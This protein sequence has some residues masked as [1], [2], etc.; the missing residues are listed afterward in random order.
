MMT[1]IFRPLCLA[2]LL[3]ASSILV[4]AGCHPTQLTTQEAR[5]SQLVIAMPGDP[6][7][8]NYAV[9]TSDYSVF[10]YL[11]S[12]ML[13]ENGLTAELE[14]ALAESWR[15]SA[16]QRQV[17]FTLRPGL[18]W[19]DGQPLTADD[20]LFTFQDIYLNP[21]I[22]TVY[23]DFFRIGQAGALPTVQK[24]DQQRVMFTLPEPFAPLLRNAG[25][26]AIL[27]SHALRDSVQTTDANGNPKFLST[28]S[29]G[30]DPHEIIGNG[31]FWIENYEPDQRLIL[32][33]N[34]YYWRSDSRGYA[35]PYIDRL[36]LQII[37]STDDQLLR[38][39]SG[40]L[41][42][43]GG[44]PEAFSLLKGEEGRG[45]YTIYNGGP[46]ARIRF[47]GFNLNQA[48]DIQGN[49]F[50]DPIKSRWFN[51]L[52]FRQA[53]AYAIDRERIKNSIYQGLGELQHSPI[54]LQSPYYLSPEEGL[55]VYHYDPQKA[56]KLLL[57]A[58]FQYNDDQ[59]L[60]DGQG[61]RVRFTILVKSEEKS[62][63]DT[64][65]LIQ[66][67]L[68]KIGIKADLQVLSF[69]IVL[70]RLLEKRDWEC[71]VGAF[72]VGM[73]EP[74]DVF[75]FWHSAG[76][77]H[78]FN[79]GPQPGN[80]PIED[81]RVSDWEREIDSLF[82]AGVKE[83]DERKRKAIYDQFQQIVAEQAPVFFLVNPLS[84]QA[85]R[86]RVQNVKFSALRGPFWNIEELNIREALN[87]TQTSRR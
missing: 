26:L 82:I 70:Q 85:I 47:V 8:F 79:Q 14:P 73:V 37:S 65:A 78:Q 43:T 30:T 54:G 69:N 83:L 75:L 66:Q 71:Y 62:R 22:P 34:P 48:R 16:D 81:W 68:S 53:V 15:I 64:A 20:V 23:R 6:Q 56:I 40:E 31:P 67:D 27:P 80:P 77:F 28:W 60:M 4:L 41:D 55:K 3:A 84:L 49:P 21:A 2:I 25:T 24:L 59:E 87:E 19:S 9:N 52:A 44:S 35:Q 17:T 46:E 33:R 7:T 38:F 39:R 29:T 61:N 18:Q 86:D 63:V 12:G 57:Q 58:G 11:Y 50:V 51:T 10:D 42:S 74:H 72:E 13:R 76:S 36:V 1:P 45:K 32:R 5:G